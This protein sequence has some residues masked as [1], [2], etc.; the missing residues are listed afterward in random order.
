MRSGGLGRRGEVDDVDETL[1][2]IERARVALTNSSRTA[3]AAHL[4]TLAQ[5]GTRLH[6]Q[7]AAAARGLERN[8]EVPM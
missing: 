5:L 7:A 1:D 8:C 2:R 6:R 4:R 3:R